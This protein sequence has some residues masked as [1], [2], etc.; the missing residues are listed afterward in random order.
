MENNYLKQMCLIKKDDF[1]TYFREKKIHYLWDKD[2]YLM[3][4][5]IKDLKMLKKLKWL[6]YKFDYDNLRYKYKSCKETDFSKITNPIDFL[7][8]MKNSEM[9]LEDPKIHQR[10]NEKQ[11]KKF[12]KRR[13]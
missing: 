9:T 6:N 8:G 11:F 7:N 2:K 5:I 1:T 13:L 10:K 12:K 4:L 3:N